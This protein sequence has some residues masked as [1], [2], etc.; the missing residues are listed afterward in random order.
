MGVWRIFISHTSELRDY[1][2]S[3]SY[4]AAAK[5][6]V[7]HAGEAV[8]DMEYFTA[9]DQRPA[10]YCRGVVAT[11][12]V[13]VAVVGF[14]YGSLVP[15]ADQVSYTRL[16]YET[17]TEL[18]IPRLVFLLDED[19]DGLGLPPKML[20]DRDGRASVRLRPRP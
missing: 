14:R 1:P 3:R 7:N 13:Y 4:V 20:V 16:E 12:D 17:A 6:A 18:G 2:A 8:M 19:A 5:D 9:R 10:D 11:A 15:D